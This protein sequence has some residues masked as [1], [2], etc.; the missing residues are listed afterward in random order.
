MEQLA[1]QKRYTLTLFSGLTPEQLA[2]RY[3]DNKWRVQ[4]I[5]QHLI[6]CERI[7]T[8]RALRFARHDITPLPG[9]EEDWYVMQS[10]AMDRS[11]TNMLEEYAIVRDAST[12]LFR[13]FTPLML[14]FTGTANNGQFTVNAMPYL[15][16]GHELHH[17]RILR[18]RYQIS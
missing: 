3:G 17:L 16:A 10:G 15:V 5:L 1:Q 14:T 12:A 2:Y 11:I 4:E 6:D 13:S 18:E 8:Y 9:F 7:L